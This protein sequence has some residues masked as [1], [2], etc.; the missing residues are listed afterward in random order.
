MNKEVNFEIAKLLKDKDCVIKPLG[1]KNETDYVEGYEWDCEDEND[2]VKITEF[3]FEDHVC[4]FKYLKPTIAEV[5]M[6]LYEKYGI[7]ISVTKDWDVGKCLGFES[8]I[9]TNDGF[10]NTETYNSPT[11]AYEAAITYCLENKI[12]GGNK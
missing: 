4:Y 12:Q 6:W 7:W 3:Q 9:D 5:V 1:L 11:E 8:I 10:V 2:T